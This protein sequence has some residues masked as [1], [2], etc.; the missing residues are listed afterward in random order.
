LKAVET[1]LLRGRPGAD[2][3]SAAPPSA[4][5]MRAVGGGFQASAPVGTIP[6]IGAVRPQPLGGAAES[7]GSA[8]AATAPDGAHIGHGNVVGHVPLPLHGGAGAAASVALRDLPLDLPLREA[9]DA[10]ERA[11]FE[12]H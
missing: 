11:Y 5:S 9:R 6:V 2:H 12:H 7:S 4:A 1:G 3:A 8:T 10:F